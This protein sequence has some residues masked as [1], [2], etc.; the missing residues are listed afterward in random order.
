MDFIHGYFDEHGFTP[1][2]REFADGVGI[3]STSSALAVIE[4]LEKKGFIKRDAKHRRI[5]ILGEDAH[6]HDWR[7]DPK[8]LGPLVVECLGCNRYSY[9]LDAPDDDD[10]ESW[11]KYVGEVQ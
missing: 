5:V 7:V 2:I 8:S 4:N 1:T 3:K 6:R 10:K 11:L 9:I